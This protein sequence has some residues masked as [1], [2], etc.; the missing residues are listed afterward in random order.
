MMLLSETL[1]FLS[2]WLELVEI[3]LSEFLINEKTFADGLRS[4][5]RREEQ[6]SVVGVVPRIVR[7]H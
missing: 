2:D 1:L 5:R 6:C 7:L 3:K 4:K